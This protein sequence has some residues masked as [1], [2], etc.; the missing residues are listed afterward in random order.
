MNEEEIRSRILICEIRE[1]DYR[2]VGNTKTAERYNQE[3]YKW[4]ELLNKI[5]PKNYEKL[6]FY[7]QGYIRLD[8]ENKQLKEQLKVIK[9]TT[10]ELLT[11]LDKNKLVLNNPNIL[12]FYINIKEILKIAKGE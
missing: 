4:E 8:D 7:K 12:D 6:K 2:E 10:N 3:K 11:Y 9:K 1:R 5:D